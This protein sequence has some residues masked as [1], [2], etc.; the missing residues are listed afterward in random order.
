MSFLGGWWYCC[1]ELVEERGEIGMFVEGLLAML[2]AKAMPNMLPSGAWERWRVVDSWTKCVSIARKNSWT[3]S[4]CLVH[5]NFKHLRFKQHFW[6]LKPPRWKTPKRSSPGPPT[7]K[8][9]HDLDLVGVRAN[10]V[11]QTI[12]LRAW[13]GCRSIQEKSPS[14]A[15]Q[16]NRDLA[17]G[18]VPRFGLLNCLLEGYFFFGGFSCS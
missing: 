12:Q 10:V 5:L 14:W 4:L 1:G 3:V 18:W 11:S 2:T 8:V 15:L 17:K 9:I 7:P 6:T 13:R 16:G